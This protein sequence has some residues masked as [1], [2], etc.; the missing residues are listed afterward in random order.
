MELLSYC[1]YIDAA[2]ETFEAV[3]KIFAENVEK[4]T[5]LLVNAIPKIE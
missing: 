3:L 2:E 4:V 1:L 5:K